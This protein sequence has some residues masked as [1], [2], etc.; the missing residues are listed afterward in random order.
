MRHLCYGSCYGKGYSIY[1]ANGLLLL[2]CYGIWTAWRK[3]HFSLQA[4]SFA[5]L[6]L[7]DVKKH[8]HSM[9]CLHKNILEAR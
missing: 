9:V 6:R 4:V 1:L 8:F 2:I 3:L 7:S 5:V